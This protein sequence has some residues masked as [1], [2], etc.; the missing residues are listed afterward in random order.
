[1]VCGQN[2]THPQEIRQ[3][4]LR[5]DKDVEEIERM[6]QEIIDL[7]EKIK[8]SRTVTGPTD[9]RLSVILELKE[10][11][12]QALTLLKQQPTASEFTNRIRT[13]PYDPKWKHTVILRTEDRDGLCD[14]L[15]T[16][17]A[18][19]KDLLEL[20][21][22]FMEIADD[23]SARFDDPVLGSIYLRAPITIAKA[24]KEGGE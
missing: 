17:E 15:D 20:C 23:G 8:N 12:S 16:A 24:K 10:I 3:V 13:E 4:I 11:A 7:L 6:R 19:N 18:I 5:S 14:R 22:E 1:M 2:P 9:E 21:E